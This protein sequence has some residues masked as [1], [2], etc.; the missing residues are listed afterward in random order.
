MKATPRP[1]TKFVATALTAGALSACSTLQLPSFAQAPWSPSQT[2]QTTPPQGPAAAD[3]DD[4]SEDSAAPQDAAEPDRL[5]EWQ[6]SVRQVSRVVIDVDGQTARFFQDGEQ[7]GWSTVATGVADFPTPTGQ[8][9]VIEKVSDKR[10]NL[11]G[12][13]Y[14]SSGKVINWDARA[15][16]DRVPD[17]GR[18]A[19][20]KMPYFL[21]LTYDG[22]GLHAGSIPNPGEPASHGCIRL[23]KEVAPVLFRHIS[24]G[25]PVTIVGSGPSYGNYAARIREMTRDRTTTAEEPAKQPADEALAPPTQTPP[26]DPNTSSSEADA[27]AASATTPGPAPLPASGQGPPAADTNGAARP[28]TTERYGP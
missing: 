21:R 12:R 1:I 19:G 26:V 28:N 23:P 22:V 20:A 11:Y 16:R 10:S 25:T 2:D 6:G 24:Y 27:I 17:G 14:N 9:E 4:S 5:Y 15:G 3:T 7:I 18:F 13:I 8:F